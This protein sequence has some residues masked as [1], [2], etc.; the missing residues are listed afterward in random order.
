MFE[1]A[2][3]VDHRYRI[4]DRIGEGGMGVVYRA[5][6]LLREEPVALKVLHAD[7]LEDDASRRR[8]LREGRTTAALRHPNIVRLLDMGVAKNAAPYLAYELLVGESLK[9]RLRAAPFSE[10]QVIDWLDPVLAALADAHRHGFVHRDLKPAN[11]ILAERRGEQTPVLIDFGLVGAFKQAVG[12]EQF[13]RITESGA[14]LGSAH[15]M[16]P[17]QIRG[18]SDVGAATDIWAAGVLAYRLASGKLPF[19]AKTPTLRMLR[20]VSQPPVPLREWVPETSPP[21]ARVVERALQREPAERWG[22]AEAFRAALL[23]A[24]R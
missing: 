8:F 6:H 3:V 1:T 5:T 18:E 7:L 10:A 11:V 2:T 17:E 13:S 9:E 24:R 22:D 12:D 20:A 4:E 16:S 15:A 19:P 21:F 14:F 23:A